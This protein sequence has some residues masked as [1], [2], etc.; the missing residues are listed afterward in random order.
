VSHFKDIIVWRRGYKGT[1]IFLNCL[2]NRFEIKPKSGRN[3]IR[4][5]IKVCSIGLPVK[6]LTRLKAQKSVRSTICFFPDFINLFTNL[7]IQ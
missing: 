2:P 6:V 7:A 4:I 1:G 5:L 3:W